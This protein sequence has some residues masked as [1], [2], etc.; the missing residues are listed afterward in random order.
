MY[1]AK[2]TKYDCICEWPWISVQSKL[3]PLMHDTNKIDVW[4]FF[5]FWDKHENVSF[6]I[7]LIPTVFLSYALLPN[8]YL[9]TIF[10]IL[11]YVR[12][13]SLLH[14]LY[15]W[16]FT[17]ITHTLLTWLR[18]CRIVILLLSRKNR[19]QIKNLWCSSL[20]RQELVWISKYLHSSTFGTRFGTARL[21][22]YITSHFS[23]TCSRWA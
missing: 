4:F 12:S 6:M 1:R 15:S 22:N 5:Y 7:M 23:C 18:T 19:A 13:S 14:T 11:S 9:A 10:V 16:S 8:C 20:P 2:S 3:E 17:N 21:G